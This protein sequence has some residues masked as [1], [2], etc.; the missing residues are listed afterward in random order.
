MR[1]LREAYRSVLYTSLEFTTVKLL[2]RL[3]AHVSLIPCH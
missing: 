3:V 2:D 1:L